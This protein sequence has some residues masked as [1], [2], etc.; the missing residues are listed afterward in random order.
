M[1]NFKEKARKKLHIFPP[2]YKIKVKLYQLKQYMQCI[3]SS[4]RYM[5]E[6]GFAYVALQAAEGGNLYQLF[7]P[8]S[9]KAFIKHLCTVNIKSV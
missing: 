5:I 9:Q 7:K 6:L 8:E 2:C 3:C 1:Q 4:L